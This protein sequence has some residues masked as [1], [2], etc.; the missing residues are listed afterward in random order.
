MGGVNRIQIFFGFLDFFY[1]YKT[2]KTGTFALMPSG[3]ISRLKKYHDFK[4][5]YDL[6]RYSRR[7]YSQKKTFSKQK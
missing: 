5:A 2:P 4:L 1:I 3:W 6:S 7:W